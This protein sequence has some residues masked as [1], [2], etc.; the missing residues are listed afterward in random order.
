MLITQRF[1]VSSRLGLRLDPAMLAPCV[2]APACSEDL[3]N[4][5]MRRRVDAQLV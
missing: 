4:L 1:A 2:A 5:L 3:A